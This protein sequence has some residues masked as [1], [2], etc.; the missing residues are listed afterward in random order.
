[1]KNF[2]AEDLICREIIEDVEKFRE[3]S[4]STQAYFSRSK[5]QQAVEARATTL[6]IAA[7]KVRT[8]RGIHPVSGTTIAGV[9]VCW[10]YENA[11]AARELRKQIDNNSR[12]AGAGT[13]AYRQPTTKGKIVITGDDDDL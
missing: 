11:V 4:D 10:T 13:G 7:E 6:N 2:V 3:Y 1:V 9:I 8:W 5:F 12:T